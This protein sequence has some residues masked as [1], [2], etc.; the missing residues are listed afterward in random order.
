[1]RKYR[2]QIT[3]LS[4]TIVSSIFI[5]G[6]ILSN[7]NVI[8]LANDAWTFI[9][10]P[11]V[12]LK[13]VGRWTNFIFYDYK[14]NISPIIGLLFD[15][16]SF[17]LLGCAILFP[18]IKK[19]DLVSLII[20][21]FFWIASPPI[22]SF[23]G[24]AGGSAP[25]NIL[26]ALF[27]FGLHKVD[28]LGY[29]ILLYSTA[30]IILFGSY[31]SHY[32]VSF[33][34]FV[35]KS[36]IHANIT[37][38]DLLKELGLW[39]CGFIIGYISW[40]AV[41]YGIY[42]KFIV[43]TESYRTLIS[44]SESHFSDL[45]AKT[46][47]ITSQIV[48][49]LGKNKNLFIQV[50]SY[51]GCL[52]LILCGLFT[53]IKKERFVIG[54]AALPA[55]G[56]AAA[57]ILSNNNYFSRTGLAVWSLFFVSAAISSVGGGKRRLFVLL[58]MVLISAS[59]LIKSKEAIRKQQAQI[60]ISK[61]TI[62]KYIPEN[63]FNEEDVIL[64]FDSPKSQNNRLKGVDQFYDKLSGATAYQLGVKN[65]WECKHNLVGNCKKAV[66]NISNKNSFCDLQAEY[67]GEYRNLHVLKLDKIEAICTTLSK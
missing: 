67:L 35:I 56:L 40:Q 10:N 63:D 23:V 3:C 38:K 1:M 14:H 43:S 54:L 34:P 29:R 32:F 58:F 65:V 53:N 22:L 47:M 64:I 16:I 61:E 2:V 50:F 11:L 25:V 45:I 9:Q 39:V 36:Y 27:L 60:L 6:F 48:F 20:L 49:S 42:S 18:L 66:K 37:I 7:T 12:K 5:Y 30:G 21:L 52:G 59:N 26:T 51:V 15:G 57:L 55:L 44:N 46:K 13:N 19:I 8:P 41:H 24:Y 17:G 28:K 31:E 62:L 4:I 33:L